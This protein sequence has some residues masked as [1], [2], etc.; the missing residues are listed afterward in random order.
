MECSTRRNT[1]R[2]DKD[3]IAILEA[4]A[5]QELELGCCLFEASVAA[6]DNELINST[7]LYL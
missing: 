4:S 5:G 3:V 1:Y 2:F 7:E 6:D